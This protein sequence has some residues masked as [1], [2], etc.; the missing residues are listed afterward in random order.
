MEPRMD[1]DRQGLMGSGCE[2]AEDDV[3]ALWIAEAQ[4]RYAAYRAG[5]LETVSGE[6]AMARARRIT[7]PTSS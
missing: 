3:D 4:R 6:E 2:K 7:R 1:T 5:T